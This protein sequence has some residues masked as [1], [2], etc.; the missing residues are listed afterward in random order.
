MPAALPDGEPVP[1]NG[2][3]PESA[4]RALRRDCGRCAAQ[5]QPTDRFG[6]YVHV[7]YCATR[8]GYCDFNTYTPGELGISAEQRMGTVAGRGI[9]AVSGASRAG[10]DIDSYLAA[11]LS[12]IEHAAAVLDPSGAAEVPMV[13]T[14]F[15]GGGT[16]TLLPVEHLA[17]IVRKL[18]SVFGLAPDAELSTEANPESVDPASL[19]ALVEAGFTRISLGMQSAVATVLTAL[20]RRHT[21]GRVVAAVAQARAAG[22]S[23]VNLDLIYGTPTETEADWR[24]SLRTAVATGVDHVSA[25]A[26]TVEPGTQLARRVSKGLLAPPDDDV[27]ADRYRVAE[28][29]LG[30]ARLQWYEISN[31]ARSPADRCRHNQL[32]WRGGHWWGFGPGAHSHVGGVRWWNVKHPAAYAARLS[33][34]VSPAHAREQLTISQRRTEDLMLRLRL[35]EGFP[36]AEL[37][38]RGR[39]GAQSAVIDGLLDRAAHDAGRA[40]L[41]LRG[42][43][44]ADTVLAQLAP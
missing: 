23:H 35:V 42:R 6:V 4:L 32:Y 7:P 14:V 18:D 3:L 2:A 38:D 27:L 40:R 36:L 1:V 43:L 30:E 16:P 5:P 39:R 37:D 20:D 11:V 13:D 10:S 9:G 25:Y 17:A 19:A 26:L 33:A 41:T 34:R 31:W 28:Q 8:C 24:A 29:M 15:F 12:E 44:L 22:F 21:P